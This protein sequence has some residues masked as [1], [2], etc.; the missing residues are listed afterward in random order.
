MATR[1]SEK[2]GLLRIVGGQWRGR[3]LEFSAADG[4]RPTADRIRE[5]LFNWL[6]SDL[7]GAHCLDLFSGS[8][9]LGLEALSRGAA[10]CLL[11]EQARQARIDISAHL[12]TLD[13]PHGECLEIDAFEL[14]QRGPG[15]RAAIDIVF[16]DPP[17]GHGLLEP[18]GT[19]LEQKGWL[20]EG[21]LIYVESSRREPAPVLPDNWQL[22]RDKTAG[23][24]RYQL[25]VRKP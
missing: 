3:K 20:A 17:F 10:S 15:H 23:D 4:L 24:V 8:G 9:A 19:L 5:T 6:A 2:K 21:A 12:A 18:A 11:V 22:H 13:A 1:R 14:L 16:M 7:H 25:F